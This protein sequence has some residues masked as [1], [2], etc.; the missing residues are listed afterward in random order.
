MGQP[1]PRRRR[2]G[3]TSP[4]PVTATPRASWLPADRQPSSP[5]R[6]R[7]SRK[8]VNGRK[9]GPPSAG[10]RSLPARGRANREAGCET[11]PTMYAGQPGAQPPAGR[12]WIRQWN[13][14]G[15]PQG[16]GDSRLLLSQLHSSIC[17]VT[18]DGAD[19]RTG[20]GPTEAPTSVLGLP[21]IFSPAEAALILRTLGLAEITECALR[22][23]AYRRRVPCHVNGRRITFTLSDLH[24][25]AEGQPRRP[26]PPAE[27]VA[28]GLMAR[29]IMR[30]DT[31]PAPSSPTHW[32]ARG[33]RQTRTAREPA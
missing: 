3:L 19:G 13:R 26:P 18:S 31:S 30:R 6:P 20:E 29:P 8:T 2:R 14:P 11:G 22:A 23:R 5:T 24:E 7:T 4:D 25:I 12:I 21:Q 1:V 32:R 15:G 28:P 17:F 10:K 33:S 9:A 27:P 16:V